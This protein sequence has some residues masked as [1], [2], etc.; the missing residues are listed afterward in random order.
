MFGLYRISTYWEYMPLPKT[1]LPG[2][3]FEPQIIR[4]FIPHTIY[5]SLYDIFILGCFVCLFMAIVNYRESTARSAVNRRIHLAAGI[6][7]LIA[8]IAT[9]LFSLLVFD[10][11]IGLTF[12]VWAIIAS[13]IAWFWPST[14]GILIVLTSV[15]SLIQMDFDMNIS[16]GINADIRFTYSILFLIFLT[17]GVLYLFSA[18][19]RNTPTASQAVTSSG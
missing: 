19:R 1:P 3:V 17:G 18:L 8:L 6:I 5:Y 4:F 10:A 12:V 11:A 2:E 13:A 9:I 16:A 15:W 14:G 7:C